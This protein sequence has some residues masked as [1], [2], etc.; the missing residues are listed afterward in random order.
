MTAGN[1]LAVVWDGTDRYG[2]RVKSGVYLCTLT[3][4]SFSKSRKMIL[5]K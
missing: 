2:M 3:T 1:D 5:V 4:P